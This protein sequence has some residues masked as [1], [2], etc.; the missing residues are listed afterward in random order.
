MKLPNMPKFH[1]CR[2]LAINTM[3]NRNHYALLMNIRYSDDPL[4]SGIGLAMLGAST[5]VVLQELTDFGFC[6]PAVAILFSVVAGL[7]L[8]ASMLRDEVMNS[9]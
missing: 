1:K 8:R 5:A 4:V 2:S 3:I 7:N 6:I 9:V